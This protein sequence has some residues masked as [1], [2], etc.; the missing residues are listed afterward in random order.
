MTSFLVKLSDSAPSKVLENGAN[1][2]VVEAED[3]A[4]AK[5]MA[6]FASKID[7]ADWA[8]AT[9]TAIAAASDLLGWK[10]RVVVIDPAA[11]AGVVAFEDVTYTGVA[12]DTIDLVGTAVAALLAANAGL[13]A[14]YTAASQ[15]LD[16][17][18]IGDD[19]GDHIVLIGF[20]PPGADTTLVSGE[21]GGV[22]GFV[23]SVV[24]EGIAAAVLT[25]TFAA[26][27]HI[28]PSVPILV[29]A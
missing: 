8:G 27:A 15:L 20:F 3:T 24:D 4:D 21:I 9:A 16:I 25:A 7:G 13:T 23:A 5:L 26:D 17:A 18:A 29:K 28:V 22:A 6:E 19:V 14:V 11:A 12:S 2:V 1:A 10:I